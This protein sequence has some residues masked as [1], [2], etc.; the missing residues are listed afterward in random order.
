MGTQT[1]SLNDRV[2]IIRPGSK[3]HKK[4]GVIDEIEPD[5]SI[6]GPSDLLMV[7]VKS[8]LRVPC[9]DDEVEKVAVED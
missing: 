2:I 4:A 7:K 8:G 1:Y 3:M 9:F 6:P 5:H